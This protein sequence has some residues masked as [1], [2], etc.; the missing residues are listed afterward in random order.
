MCIRDRGSGL[1]ISYLPQ[2]TSFLHGSL[3]AFAAE[4]QVDETLLKSM[5]R[6]L[7]FP[8]TQFDKDMASYSGGQKK[9]VLIAKSLCEQAHLYIWD[10]PLNFVDIISRI[11]LE[12]MILSYTPTM[13][14]VEHDA[15]SV[16]YT[17]LDVYKRQLLISLMLS[18]PS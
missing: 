3:S 16:S 5:L 1:I 6:K 12:K 11:Q 18:V 15:S 4:R 14:L 13:V 8:R 7:D 2:D 17:H 9:K 10:E